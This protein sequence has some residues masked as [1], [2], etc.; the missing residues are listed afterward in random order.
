MLNRSL[1]LIHIQVYYYLSSKRRS[2]TK[3]ETCCEE[4]AKL[5]NGK[6]YTHFIPFILLFIQV[7]T[8]KKFNFSSCYFNPAPFLPSLV[9]RHS[10]LKDKTHSRRQCKMSSSKKIEGE[11]GHISQSWMENT[12]MSVSPVYK[13]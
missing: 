9:E 12:N 1:I 3:V 2:E 11:R 13:L 8:T 6:Q 7:S 4:L 5:E 10:P